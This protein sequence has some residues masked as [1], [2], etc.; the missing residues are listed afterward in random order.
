MHSFLSMRD[1][2]RWGKCSDDSS[3]VHQNTGKVMMMVMIG[4]TG[5]QMVNAR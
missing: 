4:W 2:K 3:V 5:R 1:I